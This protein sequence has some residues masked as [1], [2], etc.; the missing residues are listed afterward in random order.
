MFFEVKRVDGEE[1]DQDRAAELHKRGQEY[2]QRIT[3]KRHRCAQ[4]ND[5]QAEPDDES[6]R[7]RK[8]LPAIRSSHV[9]LPVATKDQRG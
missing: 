9:M 1:Q 2:I 4:D 8:R 3:E 6:Q 7:M 5:N